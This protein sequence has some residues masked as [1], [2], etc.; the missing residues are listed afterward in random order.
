MSLSRGGGL[1]PGG[2]DLCPASFCPGGFCLG[3]NL[4]TAIRNN[5]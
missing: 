4:V 1:F 3:G 5:M 2:W